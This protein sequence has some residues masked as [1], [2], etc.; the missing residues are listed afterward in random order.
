MRGR[1]LA[2]KRGATG[3][4]ELSGGPHL[5]ATIRA[6]SRQFAPALFAEL[7]P[8]LILKLTPRATHVDF[9]SPPLAPASYQ[10]CLR[11]IA[12]TAARTRAAKAA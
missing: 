9:L 6:G 1:R 5:T 11:T 4:A 10:S 7:R 8:F 2:R 12:A 3:R